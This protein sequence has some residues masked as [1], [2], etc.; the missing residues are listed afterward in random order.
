MSK[1]GERS[2][3]TNIK[4]REQE[5][6]DLLSVVFI[7]LETARSAYKDSPQFLAAAEKLYLKLWGIR[8]GVKVET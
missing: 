7:G 1:V 8:K 6:E 5:F 2:M 4:L 3:E